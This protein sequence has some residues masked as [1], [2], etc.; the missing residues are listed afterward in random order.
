MAQRSAP[1]TEKA[2]RPFLPLPFSAVAARSE[3]WCHVFRLPNYMNPLSQLPIHI[4]ADGAD[5]S[6]VRELA[7]LPWIRGLTTNPTLLRKAGVR[8]YEA[9]AR[10][11]LAAMSG[12]PVSFEVLAGDLPG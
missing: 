2:R 5:L 1:F 4:F 8:D 11:A 3:S 10:E 9:F 12:R 6:G 7:A